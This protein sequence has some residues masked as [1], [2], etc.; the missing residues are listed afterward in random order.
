MFISDRYQFVYLEVPRTGSRSVTEALTAFDPESPTVVARRESGVAYQYHDFAVPSELVRDYC[1]IAAHRNPFSRLWSYWNHRRASGNPEVL[2]TIS[3]KRYVD[4]AC[5]PKSVPE[6]K[7]ANR[8]LPI[9]EM[10]DCNKVD[11]WLRFETFEKSWDEL[12]LHLDVKLP[13]LKR[14]NSSNSAEGFQQ[15]YDE[16]IAARVVKRYR[17][18]FDRFG[19]AVDSWNGQ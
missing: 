18:D 7:K 2:K 14:T 6:L 9:S 12:A 13:E 8:D 1:V 17:A 5:E 15:A 10:F 3:W 4:W 19:Y 11:F 16:D